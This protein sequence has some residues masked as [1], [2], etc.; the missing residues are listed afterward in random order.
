MLNIRPK[1]QMV[2]AS[3]L[4]GAF[5]GLFDIS[6]PFTKTASAAECPTGGV[7]C[8]LTGCVQNGGHYCCVYRDV[9]GTGNCPTCIECPPFGD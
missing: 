3:M 8:V 5:V 4:L 1:T 7:Q 6:L 9:Y 2:F